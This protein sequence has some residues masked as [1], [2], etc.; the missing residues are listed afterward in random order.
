M[1]NV[2][3][4]DNKNNNIKNKFKNIFANKNANILFFIWI[5]A[6]TFVMMYLINSN[7]HFTSDDYRYHYIYEN[8]MPTSDVKRITSLSDIANSM[9]NHYNIW[10]GRITAHILVQLFL[11]FGKTVFNVINSMGFVLLAL[12]VYLHSNSF[13]KL[14]PLLILF[15]I[16]MMWF[17]IPQFGASILWVS[18]SGNYLWSTIIIL[19]FLLPYRLYI[20]DNKYFKDNIINILI[21]SV[22]GIFA[23]WTNENTGGAMIFIQ[24]LFIGYYILN[25]IKLPK[26]SISGLIASLIGFALLVLAPGNYVRPN[27]P[28]ALLTK[29]SELGANSYETMFIPIFLLTILLIIYIS[30][31]SN[32]TIKDLFVPVTYLIASIASVVVLIVP[33]YAPQ[34]TW[35]GPIILIIISIGYIYSRLEFDNSLVRRISI[36][37][38]ILFSISFLYEYGQAYLDIEKTNNYVK[39]QVQRIEEE[40]A[41]GN[42]DI[43]VNKIPKPKSNYNAFKHTANITYDKYSWFNQWMAKYYG[44]DYVRI[45]K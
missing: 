16:I 20:E 28:K 5:L 32:K 24:L 39:K 10:G 17:F 2:K 23:G 26:W 36:A 35:F 1:K 41:K 34:R 3:S 9:Y 14:N 45:E 31:K 27:K 33:P 30:N 38:A 21:M 40:K 4:L 22:V 6:I 42:M 43:V 7:T 8:F 29:L 37:C 11:M 25:K 12:L 44:V 13:K 18:G 19:V 15:I